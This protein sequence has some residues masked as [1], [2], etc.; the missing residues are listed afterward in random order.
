MFYHQGPLLTFV[1]QQGLAKL[2]M[3]GFHSVPGGFELAI[4]LASNSQV[5]GMIGPYHRSWFRG[6]TAFKMAI[7]ES[8]FQKSSSSSGLKRRLESCV[9]RGLRA[10]TAKPEEGLNVC[11][12]LGNQ[13]GGQSARAK[14]GREAERVTVSLFRDAGLI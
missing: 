3:L 1:L 2:F 12:M 13:T 4:L 14:C 9:L 6:S 5:A 7:R 8:L 11:G 10:E